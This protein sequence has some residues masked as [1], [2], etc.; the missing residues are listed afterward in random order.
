[1]SKGSRFR[2]AALAWGGVLFVLAGCGVGG[3]FGLGTGTGGGTVGPGSRS[4]ILEG[5]PFLPQQEETCGPTSLGMVLRFLGD[6]AQAE[7]L[8]RETR[9]E[10]LAGTLIT[11]LAAAA[12]RR[13]FEAE[14]VDLDMSRMRERI[15]K[16]QPVI[17]LVDL[18]VWAWSRPHYMVAYGWTPE[19]V[20][21]HTGMDRGKVIPCGALDAQWAKM[22]RL[23]LIVTRGTR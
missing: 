17:L 4:V 10:G 5:V 21:A 19:G 22:G 12:R 7:D 18:G 8:V 3:D 2:D 16:G 15:R 20:V 23:A 9:T 6:P 14:V 13:G 11:D 1:M